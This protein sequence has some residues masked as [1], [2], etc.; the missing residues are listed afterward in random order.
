MGSDRT[1]LV[2]GSSSGIGRATARAFLD[3]GWTVYATARDPD[4]CRSLAE[5]GAQTPSLDVT[6]AAAVARVVQRVEDE[7][8]RLDCLVNNAGFGQYGP[9]TDVSTDALRDQFEVNLFGV[10]RLTRRCLPLLQTTGGTVVTVSSLAGRIP[11][12]GAG[13]YAASKA[14]V[15]SLSDA[16]RAEVAPLGVGVTLVEPGPVSTDFERRRTASMDELD[17]SPEYGWVYDLHRGGTTREWLLGV[18]TPETVAEHVLDAAEA[19]A[20]P[21][22][23][24]VGR[25]VGL[26]LALSRVVPESWRD[27]LYRQLF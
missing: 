3:A 19:D 22:R 17:A 4:D 14:A 2:T 7:E 16:L 10:H 1:V 23:V 21:A 5:D 12:P 25:R 15:E 11:F 13:P 8:G 24:A 18:A 9:V 27:R 6:D 20:P 26:L